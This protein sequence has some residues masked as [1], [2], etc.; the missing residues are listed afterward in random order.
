MG[1]R[2]IRQRFALMAILEGLTTIT[3]AHGDEARTS[4]LICGAT[5]FTITTHSV[6]NYVT[7]QE[8]WTHPS[9]GGQIRKVDLRQPTFVLRRVIPGL[10]VVAD[11]ISLW[12]CA[13]P[14]KAHVLILDYDCS[15]ILPNSPPA[16]FCSKTGEWYRYIAMDGT[17]LDKGF[18]LGCVTREADPRE[19]RLRI[20]LGFSPDEDDFDF[21]QTW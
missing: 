13:T 8:M 17:L 21:Q 5:R 10:T 1:L 12:G 18:G 4:T 16:R 9:G 20:R 2:M 11:E 14:P 15:Q 19:G 6:Q 7:R 3:P